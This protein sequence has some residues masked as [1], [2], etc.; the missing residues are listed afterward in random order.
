MRLIWIGVACLGLVGCDRPP[1]RYTLD[2]QIPRAAV[3][4]E[5]PP[6]GIG[7]PPY[8][9]AVAITYNYLHRARCDRNL[10]GDWSF[11]PQPFFWAAADL[12][13]RY[14]VVSYARSLGFRTP[15]SLIVAFENGTRLNV[16]FS[17]MVIHCD[18]AVDCDC[19]HDFNWEPQP[20][21]TP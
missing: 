8:D 16:C 2:C 10:S 21:H 11:S 6:A 7:T 14:R 1:Q 13:D 9:E 19:P 20:R 12:G 18:R 15:S 3:I 5:N 4:A 17:L